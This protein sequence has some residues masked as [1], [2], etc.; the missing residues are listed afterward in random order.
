[1]VHPTGAQLAARKAA[2]PWISG[3]YWGARWAWRRKGSGS[4]VAHATR[5]RLARNR[6]RRC[7]LAWTWDFR[8][9]H[10][11]R[12]KPPLRRGF[13]LSFKSTISWWPSHRSKL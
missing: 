5:L 3:R 7:E 10:S 8:Q 2:A 12:P 13:F 11:I 1:M 6:M 4:R 9:S